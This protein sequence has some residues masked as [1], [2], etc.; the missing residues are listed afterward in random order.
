MSQTVREQ[1]DEIIKTHER[2]ERRYRACA[3]EMEFDVTSAEQIITSRAS[4]WMLLRRH[5]E[6]FSASDKI[7]AEHKSLK[8]LVRWA[9]HE[10]GD[11]ETTDDVSADDL[12]YEME[13]MLKGLAS[14]ESTP[15]S[16]PPAAEGTGEQSD[17]PAIQDRPTHG[18]SYYQ[19]QG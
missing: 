7:A 11:H 15:P 5:R 8:K 10:Y 16:A 14:D 19:G 1:I 13:L 12:K 17:R 9:L 18:D 4:A 3:V 2:C 6:L